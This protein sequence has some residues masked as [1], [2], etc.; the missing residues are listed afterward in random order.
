MGY[1]CSY[2]GTY[3]ED[4]EVC[5]CPEAQAA[6]LASGAPA[7]PGANAFNQGTYNQGGFSQYNSPQG[8][9]NPVGGQGGYAPNNFGGQ[10]SYGQ[11]GYNPA[12][13]QGGY[14][15]AGGQSGYNPAGGQG[16]YNPVGGQGGYNPVGGQG[17]YNPVGGYQPVPTESFGQKVRKLAVKVGFGTENNY[18]KG[19]FE[20]GASIVPD[21]LELS[22][23]EKPVKQYTVARM[24][25][26]VIGIPYEWAKGKL[27][28][29]N[30]R[31]IF[32][33]PGSGIAGRTCLNYEFS[34]DEIAGVSVHRRYV[35]QAWALLVGLLLT[36]I[37]ALVYSLII[38]RLIQRSFFTGDIALA[39]IVS[40]LLGLG[41]MV[42]SFL[43]NKRWFLKLLCAGLA[44]PCLA[45]SATTLIAL[46]GFSRF[47]GILFAICAIIA[48]IIWFIT[49][50]RASLRP[51][52]VLQIQS[53]TAQPS[54]DIRRKT[55]RSFGLF[56]AGYTEVMPV[57]DVEECVRELNAIIT[58]IQKLGDYAVEKWQK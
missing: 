41:G 55:L 30:K 28:L 17:G 1:Y 31:L 33:A 24:N 21:C 26:R 25:N 48:F 52:L 11:G 15:P 20:E 34:V 29:T 50:V 38:P 27:Q 2:C 43:L 47:I 53:K 6:A 36:G 13:G 44:F 42:P 16:G 23:E 58:D 14:N 37:G 46:G 51:D 4:G 7:D 45:T 8:G 3:R 57:E 40:L 39:V 18:G 12:G 9:Y 19:A 5:S 35:F 54:I 10:N 32:R 56:G 49:L 22:D